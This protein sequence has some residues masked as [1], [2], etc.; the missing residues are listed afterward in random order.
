[1]PKLKTHKG[2]K[3]RVR[4]TGKGKLAYTR[5]GRR[6][7]MTGKPSKRTKQLRRGAILNATEANKVRRL[8]PY[9]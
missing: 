7:L 4:V 8:L 5:A 1:M 3:S 2:L 9:A 6:H